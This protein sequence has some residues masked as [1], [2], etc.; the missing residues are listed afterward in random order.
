[1]LVLSCF[2]GLTNCISSFFRFKTTGNDTKQPT[3]NINC[4]NPFVPVQPGTSG[5]MNRQRPL[6]PASTI[7]DSTGPQMIVTIVGALSMSFFCSFLSSGF[8]KPTNYYYLGSQVI[9]D[10]NFQRETSLA[11]T[12]PDG[13]YASHLL[14]TGCEALVLVRR[15]LG[16]GRRMPEYQ[17]RPG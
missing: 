1:M 6:R 14:Q 15:S 16:V 4:A 9:T 2:Y 3:P 13:D 5:A 17:W 12:C 7:S 10:D 8:F 11:H